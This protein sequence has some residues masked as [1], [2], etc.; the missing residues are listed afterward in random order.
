MKCMGEKNNLNTMGKTIMKK[1]GRLSGN[2]FFWLVMMT[3][4]LMSLSLNV[5]AQNRTYENAN[6]DLVAVV[7]DGEE[8]DVYFGTV[9]TGNDVNILFVN[10]TKNV[11]ITMKEGKTTTT[12]C[13]YAVASDRSSD[14]RHITLDNVCIDRSAQD[15]SYQGSD[16]A[17]GLDPEK[18][19]ALY[20][21]Y[22]PG[23]IINY[24]NGNKEYVGRLRVTLKGNNVLKG[25]KSN[26]IGDFKTYYTP[27][28]D[29]VNA[30]IWAMNLGIDGDGRLD[31]SGAGYGIY[32]KR[33]L[34]VKSGFIKASNAETVVLIEAKTI[35]RF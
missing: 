9:N 34:F 24:T 1:D 10:T 11:T 17:F 33:E 3:M 13:I 2:R 32:A 6:S 19:A 22:F 20:A 7:E 30:G 8:N 28:P 5:N 21:V 23:S 16:F 35:K 18:R 4:L 27:T 12:D 15:V 14:V 29:D 31:V 25:V 26:N